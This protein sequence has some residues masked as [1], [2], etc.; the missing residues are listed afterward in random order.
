MRNHLRLILFGPPGAGKG[1]Q[2]DMLSARFSVPHIS[3]GDMFR[4]AV[5]R[6]EPL[7]MRVKSFMDRGMLVSDDLVIDLVE[8]RLKHENNKEGF[9]L[10][11][12]PRTLNQ[13][14]S[15]EILLEKIQLPIDAVI[16][17]EVPEEELIKRLSGRRVCQGCG[18]N[19][20][21]LFSP[22]PEPGV[23]AKCGSR[24]YQRD[25]DKEEVIRRRLK[26][27]QE[28]TE[29][30]LEFYERKGSLHTVDGSGSRELIFSR[31][32]DVIEKELNDYIEVAAR[33][34]IDKK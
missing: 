3:T 11:G 23:C 34:R 15:L 22:P 30:L 18:Q 20:H 26:V 4:E 31:V 5:S 27:Y 21:I 9:I 14:Q 7:G 28:Q 25:D 19:Y 24:L 32:L 29:A 17:I 16:N 12:F 2:A 33:D 8:E 13:A 6:G 10:D 1:T